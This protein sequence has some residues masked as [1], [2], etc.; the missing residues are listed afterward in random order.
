MPSK[1]QAQQRLFAAAEHGATFPMAQKL[2][3]S[4]TM[5]QLHDFASTRR[6]GLPKHVKKGR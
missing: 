3:G 2:R 6:K 4:M 1:S 5:K